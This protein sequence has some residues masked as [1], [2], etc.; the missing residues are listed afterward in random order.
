MK[1]WLS[2]SL[3]LG[4]TLQNLSPQARLQESVYTL[5]DTTRWNQ[6]EAATRNVSPSYQARFR[7]RRSSWGDSVNVAEVDMV[8]MQLAEDKESATS[9]ITL[10]WTDASGVYLHRSSVTQKWA[11]E[12]GNFRLV[13]ETIKKG[14]ASLFAETPT[15]EPPQGP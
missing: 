6:L 10:S 2:L 4:C 13:D 3:L 5:N 8:F 1:H 7:A 14:D 9:E 12:H 11:N 15:A